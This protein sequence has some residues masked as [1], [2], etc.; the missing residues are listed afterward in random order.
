MSSIAVFGG[1]FDPVHTG[2]LICARDILEKRPIDQIVFI[3]SY[4][5]PFKTGK[6]HSAPA[7][8]KNMLD[9]AIEQNP[10]FAVSDMEI[11]KPEISYTISTIR[12]LKKTYENIELI[13]GYDNL[14]LFEEWK[15]PDE[16]AELTTLVVMKR[17]DRELPDK[18]NRFFEKSVIVNTPV[19]EIS[20]SDIRA[21]VRAGKPINYL[22]PEPVRRYIEENELYRL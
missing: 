3:P 21:R 7:H 9:L 4:V 8:R 11:V 5:T 16:L 2:H 12:E 10:C 18:P 15:E 19:I 20:S 17:I 6:E 22:V 14:L 13:I 1:T